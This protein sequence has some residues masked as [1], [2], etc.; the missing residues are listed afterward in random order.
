[1]EIAPEHL[2]AQQSRVARDYLQRTLFVLPNNDGEAV[3]M[4]Q[5]LQALSAPHV[6]ISQQRWGAVLEKE[7]A[8]VRAQLSDNV[9]VVCIVEMPGQEVD[10]AGN[11][12]CEQEL[13][14]TGVQV[15]VIDHH[16][17]H[18]VDRTHPLSSLEQLCAKINWRMDD[19][20]VHIAV[21]DRSWVPGLLALGL[22]LPQIRAV[23]N[24]DLQAQ[25]HTAEA[26]AK[27]TDAAQVLLDTGKVQ[28]QD[29]MYVLEKSKIKEAILSQE[30][31]LRHKDG[32]VNIFAGRKH[33]LHFSGQPAV[34]DTLRQVD[35]AAL[36]YPT[37]YTIYGGGDGRLGKF[38]GLKTTRA[39]DPT[40]HARL[41]EKIMPL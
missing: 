13:R 23:R 27:H 10:K 8:Q 17:Y 33:K 5:I 15:E 20:D 31:A 35:Y 29:G 41:L 37:P 1:M 2:Q 11:I 9:E 34:V 26:I 39:I 19:S 28:P 3:R 36:G 16:F 38:F 7:M 25:G 18:W 24:F 14:A 32:R 4:R 6:L 12:R 40:C 22:S 21:N 30:I